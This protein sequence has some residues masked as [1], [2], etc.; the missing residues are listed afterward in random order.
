MEEELPQRSNG[1]LQR[2][3]RKALKKINVNY[4]ELAQEVTD[5]YVNKG[6]TRLQTVQVLKRKYGR[7]LPHGAVHNVINR[8]NLT[9]LVDS[10]VEE[11]RESILKD[12]IP[13]LNSI[14]GVNLHTLLEFSCN[15]AKDEQ[16]KAALSVKDAKDL[17]AL[18]SDLN[19]L[20]RLETGQATS[21]VAIT[22]FTGSSEE[23]LKT[24]KEIIEMDPVFSEDSKEVIFEE[25]QEKID[26]KDSF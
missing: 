17:A 20:I 13:V 22:H 12:K 21:N 10:Q 14:M 15:L 2:S 26:D 25:R 8:Y 7:A 9:Q 16:R 11:A 4:G 5:L 6:Y 19:T 24:A 18:V 3:N 23:L 1:L